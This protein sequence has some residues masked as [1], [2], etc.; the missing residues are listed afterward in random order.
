MF[1]SECVHFRV[2]DVYNRTGP[3]AQSTPRYLR[4]LKNFQ[5]LQ[6]PQAHRLLSHASRPPI[7]YYCQASRP[8][9]LTPFLQLSLGVLRLA[10][11]PSIGQTFR[12]ELVLGT[13]CLLLKESSY[14]EFSDRAWLWQGLSCTSSWPPGAQAAPLPGRQGQEL[15]LILASRKARV[16]HLPGQRE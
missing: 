1:I 13:P 5:Y 15:L 16:A 8:P 6:L 3:P 7:R 9:P 10:Q 14:G 12:G 2:S 4:L 11:P